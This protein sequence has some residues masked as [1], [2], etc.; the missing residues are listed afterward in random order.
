[1]IGVDC[2]LGADRRGRKKGW[3]QKKKT[4][5][6]METKEDGRKDGNERK[7]TI[8]EDGREDGNARTEENLKEGE[9]RKK[10]KK[11][12]EMRMPHGD[13]HCYFVNLFV[14][15]ICYFVY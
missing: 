1:M 7:E 12:Y 13:Y 10:K 15:N 5:E 4:G 3:K 8:E 2:I 14:I 9:K 6:R 11:K